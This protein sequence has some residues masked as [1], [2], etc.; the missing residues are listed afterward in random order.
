M[1]ITHLV[2]SRK[3]EGIFFAKR[4][5]IFV[6]DI[7]NR[8]QHN[9]GHTRIGIAVVEPRQS[10]LPPQSVVN[11]SLDIFLVVTLTYPASVLAL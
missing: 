6:L 10:S 8:Q 5:L 11:M 9:K 2:K 3:N 1:Y 7:N 4:I